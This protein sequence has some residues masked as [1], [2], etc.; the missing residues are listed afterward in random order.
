MRL[1]EGDG[2]LG[3]REVLI[4]YECIK[5]EIR[6]DWDQ[7]RGMDPQVYARSSKDPG[8]EAMGYRMPWGIVNRE[9]KDGA[10]KVS[11]KTYTKNT[12][13]DLRILRKQWIVSELRRARRDDLSALAHLPVD[14]FDGWF[15]PQDTKPR[16][17]AL[18]AAAGA[19]AGHHA[20]DG[21]G[22]LLEDGANA[23]ER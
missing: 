13:L 18:Q 7:R 15:L 5:E 22:E 6:N 12:D 9:R 17:H 19:L 8:I 3:G 1:E 11:G 10:S 21:G 14:E 16:L 2:F 23:G 4:E 20:V